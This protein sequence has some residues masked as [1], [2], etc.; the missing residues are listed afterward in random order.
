MSLKIYVGDYNQEYVTEQENFIYDVDTEF[1]RLKLQG[2]ELERKA[3][4]DIE[5]G[6]WLNETAF[7][8]RFGFKL[9]I[10]YIS[11]GC[12]IALTVM[13]RPEKIIN[14]VEAGLEVRDFIIKYCK[15][16]AIYLPSLDIT[17]NSYNLDGTRFQDRIEAELEGKHFTSLGQLNLYIREPMPELTEVE[18]YDRYGG[19]V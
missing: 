16:G 8:D 3:L 19:N 11:T 7:I 10:E 17:V 15:S 12:K 13:N 6:Q 18:Y 9:Y 14:A 1:I 4:K 5:Q 2:T